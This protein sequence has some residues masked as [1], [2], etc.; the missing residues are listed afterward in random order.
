MAE[1]RATNKY[2]PPDWD[3]SKGSANT[4]QKSHHLRQRARK[5]NEGILVVRFEM[6]FGIICSGCEK[7]IGMGVRYNAEKTKTG[8]YYTTQI[9][10]FK[11][12]CHLCDNHF[13]IETDPS[14]FDYKI[15]AGA[16][17]QVR[18]DRAD[19]SE[20]VETKTESS[21]KVDDSCDL[22]QSDDAMSRL[23]KRVEDRIQTESIVSSLKEL[24]EWRVKH[25][26]SF[27]NNQILRAQYRE[28]RRNKR[29]ERQQKEHRE[30]LDI[31]KRNHAKTMNLDSRKKR[32]MNMSIF[33]TRFQSE[34]GVASSSS[35]NDTTRDDLRPKLE[36]TSSHHTTPIDRPVNIKKET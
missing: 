3:P 22:V 21:S 26:E 11:M 13:E 7:F 35:T 28:K 9:Y 4:Y 30:K 23:E 31:I 6:P 33:S 24:K 12:K 18:Y 5:I 27:T 25:D 10:K 17:K 14:K 16:R 29:L 19:E 2:Y 8:K 1:R 34:T 15:L 36:A 20:H 32:Y